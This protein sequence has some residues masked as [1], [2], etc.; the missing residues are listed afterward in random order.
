M[1]CHTSLIVQ[2]VKNPP[3]MQETPVQF[4]GLNPWVVKIH[5]RRGRLLTPVFLGSP[6]G[7]AGWRIHLQCGRP[8][9]YPWVGKIPWRRERLQYSG[10]ENSMDCKESDTTKQLSLSGNQGMWTV[11]WE[12][13]IILFLWLSSDGALGNSFLCRLYFSHLKMQEGMPED[14]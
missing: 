13:T 11:T 2:L 7:S 12:T 14:L 4:L 5:W 1:I 6:C 3:A 10:L 8:G 9:F